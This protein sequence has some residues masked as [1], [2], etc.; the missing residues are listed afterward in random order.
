MKKLITFALLLMAPI[1]A[2]AQS[3]Y[4]VTW[5]ISGADDVV[6]IQVD[7]DIGTNFISAHG[8]IDF[9]DG[10]SIPTTGTCFFSL[11]NGIYCNFNISEGL[12]GILDIDAT[13]DGAWST[14]DVDG[15][16]T[17]SGTAILSDVE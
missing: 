3:D 15:E 13:L 9:D 6:A 12:T 5:L 14:I 4:S 17:A 16:I 2:Y 7:F 1:G 11:D 10:F 8:A